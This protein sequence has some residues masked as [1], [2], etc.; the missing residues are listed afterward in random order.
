MSIGMMAE[1]AILPSWMCI[2]KPTKLSHEESAAFPV[3]FFTAYNGLVQRGHLKE[4]E[5]VFIT[6]AAGGMGA[7][8]IQLAKVDG[9]S[10][11]I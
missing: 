11:I 6:G 5:T 9:R 2:P 7:S 10:S 4:G 8:A 1:E 3:G